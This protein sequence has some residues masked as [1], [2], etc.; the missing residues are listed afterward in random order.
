MKDYAKEGRKQELKEK[1]QACLTK[2]GR[3]MQALQNFG[4]SH[5]L[6][7]LE[8]VARNLDLTVLHSIAADLGVAKS[9][10]D[11]I[12]RELKRL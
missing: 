5:V 3:E 6:E 2:I 7:T 8:A 1:R 11:T 4:G 12:E 9:E 10:F